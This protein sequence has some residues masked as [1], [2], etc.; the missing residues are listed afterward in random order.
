MNIRQ[1]SLAFVIV[2]FALPIVT[3]LGAQP[4]QIEVNYK[5]VSLK[6]SD[7]TS[8]YYYPV[9]FK[10]YLENDTTL[11]LLDYHYLYF[12]FTFQKKYKPY[13]RSDEIIE[14]RKILERNNLSNNDYKKLINL[15]E[16]VLDEFPFDL[17][18]VLYMT[19]SNDKLGADDISK[20]WQ[21]K[22]GKIIET[23]LSSGDGISQ[24]TAM[25]V[26][27]TK[28][29]YIIIQILGLE[30]AGE[31][32]LIKHFDRMKIEENEFGVDYLYFDIERMF[33]TLPR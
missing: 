2:T 8:T 23:I 28:D 29:E 17:D 3:K 21:Y 16:K 6:V 32:S 22:Y 9:L 31:Q 13:G 26:I 5:E 14:I 27:T 4:R 12:G 25:H 1:I 18:A 10:R 15:S 24:K 20:V 7:P 19:M 11:S 30:F 33:S